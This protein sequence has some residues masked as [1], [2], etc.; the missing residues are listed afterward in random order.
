MENVCQILGSF[1]HGEIVGL[2]ESLGFTV[3]SADRNADGLTNGLAQTQG[4]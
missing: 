3:W 2:A 1:E 4:T